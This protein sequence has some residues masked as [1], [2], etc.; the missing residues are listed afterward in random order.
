M[1]CRLT[2]TIIHLVGRCFKEYT[3]YKPASSRP[4]NSERYF[5]GKRFIGSPNKVIEILKQVHTNLQNDLYPY[6]EISVEEKEF[7]ESISKEYE[8]K[9]ILCIDEAKKFALNPKLYETVYKNHF[10]ASKLFCDKFKLPLKYKTVQ[11]L[12]L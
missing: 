12:K 8:K 4:C 10:N 3:I 5:I 1:S 9:Q 7:I 6:I 11:E 2:K